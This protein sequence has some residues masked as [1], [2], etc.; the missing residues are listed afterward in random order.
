MPVS[1]PRRV[2][3]ALTAGTVAGLAL[4]IPLPPPAYAEQRSCA[5][6]T[7]DT[8][9]ADPV[10][11]ASD[12]L[13]T[14]QV[15]EAVE[16]LRS[17]GKR[18]GGGVGIAVVDSG[19][20]AIAPVDVVGPG[21]RDPAYARSAAVVDH[22]GTTV[23]GLIAGAPRDN[24]R[25]VGIAPAATLHDVRVYDAE[26]AAEDGS[27]A[28]P[29]ADGVAAGL[30][31]VLDHLDAGPDPI[32]IVNVSVEV[33]R[34]EEVDA[35]VARLA[36][37]GVAV[38]ASAGDR[39]ATPADDPLGPFHTEDQ[40]RPGE[41]AARFVSPAGAE[42]AVAVSATAPPGALPW[43][44]VVRSSAIDVAVPTSGGVSYGLNGVTCLVPDAQPTSWAAAEVSG[45]LA[46]LMS[47]YD[48]EPTERVVQR[49]YRTA[50][51]AGETTTRLLGHGIVQPVEALRR[52]LTFDR[53]GRP[54]GTRL[55]DQVGQAKAPP[56]ARDVLAETR[57]DAL[58]WGLL[59]GGALVLALLLRPVLARRRR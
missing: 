57:H 39:P 1:R 4:A 32:R 16:L 47:A 20:S 18:P 21:F 15:E 19:I 24:G 14:L 54:R 37:E 11:S 27:Q 12:P 30:R 2:A 10:A 28:A 46:L 6:V 8:T 55:D 9:D 45:V 40:P 44:Y 13:V 22:H 48:D 52:P 43:E 23:A 41:D 29:T 53:S 59:G 7:A 34:D 25:P 33:E 38:V 49:L 42:D 50:T 51:G 35:L 3:V 36:E 5:D 58:W 26:I 31:W 56:P 17:R